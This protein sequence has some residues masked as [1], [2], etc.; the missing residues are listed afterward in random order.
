ME[1]EVEVIEN[2]EIIEVDN[3]VKLTKPYKFE[4]NEYTEVELSGLENITARDMIEANRMHDRSGGFS[5]MPEL[6]MEYALVIASRASKHP[7]EF[8]YGLPPR[9]A[10]RVKNKVTSFFFGRA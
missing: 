10:L 1:R 3:V 8:Y 4:G 2:G 5:F 9:D 7:I 6:S